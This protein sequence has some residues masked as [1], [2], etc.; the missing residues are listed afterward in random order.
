M[1]HPHARALLLTCVLGLSA[2]S[3]KAPAP[4]GFLPDYSVLSPQPTPSG[5]TLL[6]WFDPNLPKGR[7][8]QVYLAPSRLYP[9]PTPTPRIPQSTL[10]GI[11]GYYDA[12]LRNE[13]GKVMKVVDRPGP[14]TL[15]VRPVITRVDAYTQ[16]LHVY[17]WLPVTLVAAGVSTAAGWRDLDSEIASELRFEAGTS[18]RVIGAALLTG[19]GVPLENDQQTLTAANLKGVLDGWATDLRQAYA[20]KYR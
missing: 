4:T 7:Y 8:I 19:T 18:G 14:N 1:N 11:T 9:A 17:E 3:S 2:C 13:L 16:P 5:G 15:V 20:V 10:V 12:A 6:S